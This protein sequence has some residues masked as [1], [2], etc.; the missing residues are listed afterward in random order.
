MLRVLQ[1]TDT[2][3]YRDVGGR[4]VGVNTENSFMEVMEKVLAQFW[5]VDLILATGDLVHDGSVVGYQRFK[6][7]FEQLGVR[8]LVIPGNHDKPEVMR[9]VFQGGL[10]SYETSFDLQGWRF[11]MLDSTLAGSDGGTLS[12]R[13]LGVAREAID[14][15]G[16]QHVMV[17][18]HH[19]PISIR[20]NWIDTI[21]VDN[22]QALIDM[23]NASDRVRAVVWGHVH[24]NF[25][26]TRDGVRL[27]ATPSTCIQFKPESEDFALDDVPPGFRWFKLDDKGGIV[28]GVER[29]DGFAEHVDLQCSGYT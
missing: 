19:H 12:E 26:E 18:L 27:L 1:I 4:L 23:V 3:L 8:T 10:V 2:H 15:A 24:Q 6:E 29:I 25:D 14:T 20:S 17:C 21:G 28:T 22:G 7:R 13:E 9:E 16:D 5:P 11:V